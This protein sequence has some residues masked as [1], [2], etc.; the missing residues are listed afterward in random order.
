MCFMWALD[1]LRG[2]SGG[3][4][5]ETDVRRLVDLLSAKLQFDICLGAAWCVTRHG[6]RVAG[7]YRFLPL[8]DYLY[9][10]R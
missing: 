5:S 8:W 7:R 2:F 6:Y 1:I 9:L 4:S 10:M 3:V